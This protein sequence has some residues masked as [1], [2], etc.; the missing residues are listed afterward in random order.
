[1]E[2][3]EDDKAVGLLAQMIFYNGKNYFLGTGTIW[4]QVCDGFP[5][6]QVYGKM[7]GACPGMAICPHPW[8]SGVGLVQVEF[9]G[10]FYCCPTE[11]MGFISS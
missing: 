6:H 5:G 9:R 2:V 7:K 11:L 10:R 8:A 1:M 4:S 3:T